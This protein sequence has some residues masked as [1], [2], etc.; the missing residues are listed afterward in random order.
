MATRVGGNRRKTRHI[1]QNSIRQKG[2]ISIRRY[3]HDFEQGQRVLLLAQ[4]AIQKGLY[5]RRF[6]GRSGIV[7]GKQG[8]CYKVEVTDKDMTKKIIVHPAH[9][10]LA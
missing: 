2:K 5:F 7:L 4:P 6:H 9:L 10:K 3:L 1:F 8:D